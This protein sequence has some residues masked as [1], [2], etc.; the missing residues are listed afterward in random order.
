MQPDFRED[1]IGV[2]DGESQIRP[3]WWVLAFALSAAMWIAAGYVL[4]YF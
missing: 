3:G 1:V 4:L 2:Q